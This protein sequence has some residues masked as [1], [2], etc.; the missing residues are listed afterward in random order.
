MAEKGGDF[1]RRDLPPISP[2]EVSAGEVRFFEEKMKM[3]NKE[4]QE[5]AKQKNEREQNKP[6]HGTFFCETETFF[7]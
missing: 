5:D 1:Y 3:N 7:F 6:E 2:V 4:G